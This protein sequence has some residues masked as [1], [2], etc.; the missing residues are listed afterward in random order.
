MFST[1]A[2][3]D[4]QQ[5]TNVLTFLPQLVRFLIDDHASITGATTPMVIVDTYSSAADTP[6]EVP[7]D[8]S[9][10][11]SLGANNGWAE[12]TN[13]AADYIILGSPDPSYPFQI[14]LELQSTSVL[15][16]ILAPTGGFVT[17]NDNNDM[18]NAGNWANTT[19][20]Y[21]DFSIPTG[22]PYWSCWISNEGD[23]IH[24]VA[25][26]STDL[27]YTFIGKVVNAAAADTHPYV[28]YKTENYVGG[29]S[30]S[31]GV[32]AD[33][34]ARISAVTGSEIAVQGISN[35]LAAST[36]ND[37]KVDLD[38]NYIP[39]IVALSGDDATDYKFV[40]FVNGLKVLPSR[41]SILG[42][43]TSD[44]DNL[45]YLS[46]STGLG[47]LVLPWTGSAY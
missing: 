25:D 22:S 46:T 34:W 47:A 43:A 9:N 45:L 28:L 15:R 2:I 39:S 38:G 4:K 23:S 41:A 18:T 16:I 12:G 6:H 13:V 17:G 31:T 29:N 33:D 27:C 3:Y 14:G 36:T 5:Q 7:S 1:F 26:N 40:G 10:L 37:Y 19:L 35:T 42:V 11:D 24:L 32:T 20:T 30:A 8:P 44:D 21:M